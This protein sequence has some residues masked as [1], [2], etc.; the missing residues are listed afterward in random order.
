MNRS[1]RRAHLL[2]SAELTIGAGVLAACGA[3]LTVGA[4]AALIA[5]VVTGL[6]ALAGSL[7]VRRRVFAAVQKAESEAGAQGYAEG[8][9][10]GVLMSVVTYAAAVFPLTGPGGVS[11]EER[12]A[13]RT[14]AY[15]IAADDG[16]PHKVRTAAAAALEAI[17]DGQDPERA[18]EAVEAL[19][20]AVYKL[21]HSQQ[22]AT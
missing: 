16:L 8:L 6:G 11:D 3:Y 4:G 17:D 9:A 5:G 12:L 22:D 19:S 13:R 10:Q 20:W 18:L 21:R 1:A 7:L 14:I 15:R 2:M